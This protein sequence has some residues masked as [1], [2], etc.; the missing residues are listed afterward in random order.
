MNA[1]VRRRNSSSGSSTQPAWWRIES[2]SRNGTPRRSAAA[3]PTVDLPEPDV[4]TIEMRMRRRRL[5]GGPRPEQPF[6]SAG[7]L[8]RGPRVEGLGQA[9][10]APDDALEQ[11]DGPFVVE[12]QHGCAEDG[13]GEAEEAGKSHALLEVGVAEVGDAVLREVVVVVVQHRLELAL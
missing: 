9:E 8:E 4:P 11:G 3:R 6:A 2:S 7:C 13:V 1:A 10:V 5:I 12:G